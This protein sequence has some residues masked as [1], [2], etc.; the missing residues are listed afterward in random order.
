MQ[1]APVRRKKNRFGAAGIKEK[2][3]ARTVKKI[4]VALRSKIS[5]RWTRQTLALTG[6]TKTENR[7][8]TLRREKSLERE[9]ETGPRYREW[10]DP[11]QHG[12]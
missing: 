2:R 8:E 3:P 1:A 4:E 9:Q 10:E 6:R 7:A 12:I 5:R 11:D